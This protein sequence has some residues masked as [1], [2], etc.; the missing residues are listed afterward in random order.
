[1]GTFAAR[2]QLLRRSL[3]M[4]GLLLAASACSSF[5]S[6][7]ASAPGV[8]GE[9]ST[10]PSSKP[11]APPSPKPIAKDAEVFD[12]RDF[13][14]VVAKPGD[15]AE[16]LA[17]RHLGDPNKKWMIED[18][19]GVRTF[20]GGQEVVIPKHEWNPVGVFPWGYQL[21][22]VLVYHNIST[23]DRGKLSIGVRHFEAQMRSLHAEGFRTV[24]LGDFLE[25][26]AGRRQLPRKS[27]VLT[28]DDGYR[29]F[30]QYARP[31][32]KDFG[33]NATLFVY[34]DF[35]GG[36]SGLSWSDLRAL[37]TEG[38]DVQAHSKTHG[39]LRRKED[40]SQAAYAKRIESELAYP[41]DLL[42]KHLG[43]AVD[44]LAYPYGDTDEEVLRH[45]VKYGY[46][47]AF[48][49]RRQSNPAF[50]FP[51]KISR[52]QI[53][54]EMTPKDF[55]RNLTVFQDEEVE[56]ARASDGK[57]AGSS[58]AA[59]AQP[60]S[61]AAAPPLPWARDRL[62]ASHNARSE[63]LEQRGHLR[64]AL[65]E[66]AIALTINPGDRGA[67]EAQKRLE[68]RIAQEVAGLLKEGR[69]LLGRGLLGEAQQ[70]FLVALSLDPTNRTAFETLQ[71]EVREVMSIVHTVR[72]GDTCLSL[73]ELYYGDRLRCEVIA[74]TNRL[75]LNVPL[76][77][78]HKLK[79]PEI[80]GVPFQLR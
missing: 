39:N 66:R 27:V 35:I 16:G 9:P 48:T 54:S 47:A 58:G 21:V 44:T 77:P 28:F 64:Q 55:A 31:L 43:R 53:Y 7:Q 6:D 65:E 14:V 40:E 24:S 50:V 72:S 63:Q 18:Y 22:P 71:N 79:I 23:E 61:T 10:P 62:V 33:F 75:A 57:L 46:V 73:A 70:R 5:R 15:T 42:R 74:E 11:S 32:L 52:S 19:T 1:M 12:S 59:R 25:F 37:V 20:S 49:V 41:L 17:A 80:P 68:G 38:F 3:L 60:V 13:V 76:R 29:S 26:T 34:S 4:V 56:T 8:P 67:Q 78:G 51:L 45:V 2:R 69:A 30:I 36:G